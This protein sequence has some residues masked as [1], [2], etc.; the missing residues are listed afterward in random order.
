VAIVLVI[1]FS[2]LKRDPRVRRQIDALRAEHAVIAAGTGDPE[3]PNV[4]FVGCQRATRTLARKLIEAVELVARRYEAHYSHLAH[5]AELRRKLSGTTFDVAIAND[6][7]ALPLALAL[8]GKRP[9]ILDAHEYAP[10]ELEERAVWRIFKQGYAYYLCHTY[11]KRAT[12][13]ITVAPG[14]AEEYERVFDVKPIVVCNAAPARGL[15]VRPT[16]LRSIRMI[17][18]GHAIPTRRIENM[19]E[20]TRGLDGRFQLDLVLVPTFPRYLEKLKTMSGA[21]TRVRFLPPLP[22]DNIVPF[23]NT[24]DIGLYLL[25]PSSFNNLHALPNKFFEF[26]Q[27]RL[28]VAIGPSPEMARIVSE[29]D[30]GVVAND[31]EPASLAGT[32]NRLTSADIDRM[33]AGSERAARV[34]NAEANAEKLRSIVAS[35]LGG[36]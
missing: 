35:V 7:E 12:R 19:I 30:C 15:V 22:L 16:P 18:H 31:F 36:R 24:Y 28:A 34:H 3:M 21:D 25:Q 13:V 20:V 29:F 6:V 32:L 14:I 27:A 26:I 23:S 5:V 4:H 9:V 11:L 1:S 17:H 2:D 10:R 8:A 33:K